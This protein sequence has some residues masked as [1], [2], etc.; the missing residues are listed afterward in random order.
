[1]LWQLLNGQHQ[2]FLKGKNFNLQFLNCFYYF[3]LFRGFQPLDIESTEYGRRLNFYKWSEQKLIQTIDLG[4]EGLAPLEIRFLHDPKQAQG[5]VGTALYS[6]VYRFEKLK[7]KDEFIVEKVIDVPAKKVTGWAMP[8]VNGMMSDILLSLD[9]KFIYFSNW[10]HGD[11]RQYDITNPSKPK[12]TAQI[13]LGGVIVSDSDVI[14]T[15]DKELTVS[16]F[17]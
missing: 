10:L 5:F 11:V 13:F 6:N 8:E 12:L 16:V 14:V 17:F 1:M 2:I 9:D 7:D 4:P 3:I 15:E